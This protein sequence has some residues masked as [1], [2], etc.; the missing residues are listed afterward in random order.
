MSKWSSMTPLLRPVTKMKCSMPGLPRL[1]D[2]VLE[3][4]P[5]D[6]GQHLL[7]DR[8]GGGQKA[9]AEAGDGKNGFAD[10]FVHRMP[11]NRQSLSTR[12]GVANPHGRAAGAGCSDD[13]RSRSPKST[14]HVLSRSFAHQARRTQAGEWHERSGDGRRRLYRRPH[15][16]GAPRRRR[17]VV[18]LD[19]LSTGFAWAVPEGAS[20]SSAIS[21][22]A[23]ASSG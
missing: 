9:G 17:T 12:A 2:H 10:G 16:A 19:D 22:T 21:A 23:N 6:D 14:C 15:G 3:H 8:L 1:V 11:R 5:V 4:R 20:S 18:V 7:R 13:R